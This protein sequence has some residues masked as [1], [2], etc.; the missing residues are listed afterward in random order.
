MT[1]QE[2]EA[3]GYLIDSQGVILDYRRKVVP[4]SLRGDKKV[5]S[6]YVE[7]LQI[8]VSVHRVVAEK[9]V[10]GRTK[11]REYILFV[12]YDKTNTHPSNMRWATLSEVRYG[13]YEKVELQLCIERLKSGQ[14]HWRD[15]VKQT[16]I[17]G[18]VAYKL[19]KKA[20][21]QI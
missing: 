10:K 19:W 13:S 11:E 3:L 12:D 1:Y 5:I 14:L 8:K 17:S 2:L 7:G 21:E 18:N 6:V 16:K 20:N 15:A 9:Y 4:T